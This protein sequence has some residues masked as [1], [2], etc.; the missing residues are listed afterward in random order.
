MLATGA[1]TV[2][3][4]GNHATRRWPVP[5]RPQAISNMTARAKADGALPQLP[6]GS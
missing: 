2:P 1:A 3:K 5:T 6:S 4:R